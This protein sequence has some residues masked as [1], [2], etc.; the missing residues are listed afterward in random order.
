[1][2]KINR[3]IIAGRIGGDIPMQMKRRGIEMRLV[4]ENGPSRID[5]TL[6][7]AIARAHAWHA[8]WMAGESITAIAERE[9]CPKTYVRS[10][11]KLVFLAPDIIEDIIAGDQPADMMADALIKCVTLPCDWTKQKLIVVR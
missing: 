5:Q 11:M 9:N 4:I 8:E 2:F 10:V 7:K 3:Q 1:V 6:I